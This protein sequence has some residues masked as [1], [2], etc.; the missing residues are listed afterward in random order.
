MSNPIAEH[1]NTERRHMIAV[2][3]ALAA[4]LQASRGS[5]EPI[6]AC[7]DYLGY[8]MGR[9]NE[10]GRANLERLRPRVAAAGN[11]EDERIMADI[12]ATIG[13]TEAE[14]GQLLAAAAAF[15]DG[16]EDGLTA[17]SQAADAFI[18]FY[19]SILALRKNP[20]QEIIG[21]Y[22]DDAEYWALTDDVTPVSIETEK[23]LFA[24]VVQSG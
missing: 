20:A 15:R 14:L 5:P 6:L 16:P 8:V 23:N 17:L 19:N 7:V 11:R 24:R 1:R 13:R 18:V 10:Q 21:R 12:A 2:K 9:F 22:F 4:G 3:D